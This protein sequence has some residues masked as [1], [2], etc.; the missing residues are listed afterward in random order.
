MRVFLRGALFS[1]ILTCY[2]NFIV[3]KSKLRRQQ[4]KNFYKITENGLQKG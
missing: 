4:V 3:R 1:F 2:T